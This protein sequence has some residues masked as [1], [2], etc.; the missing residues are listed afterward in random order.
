[1]S[2]EEPI[3][4]KLIHD[5]K[6]A[7]SEASSMEEEI[8]ERIDHIVRAWF[9][10]FNNELN[11]WYFDGAAEG[12]V[13]DLSKYM[14]ADTIWCIWTELK[15]E[16]P[17]DMAIIDKNGDVYVWESSIPTRWLFEDFED[18]IINGKKLYEQK[19]LERK[20]KIKTLST[21]KKIEDRLLVE[22]AKKKLSKKELAALKRS[23]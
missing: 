15:K 19:E 13:G 2:K 17:H 12:E 7:S 20:A 9:K 23:L 11:Y 14:G 10:A 6:V 16:C 3:T 22:E 18:E 5:W 8:I 21:Q 4:Q 1:M